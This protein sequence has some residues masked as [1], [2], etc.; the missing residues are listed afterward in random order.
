M[1]TRKDLLIAILYCICFYSAVL[2]ARELSDGDSAMMARSSIGPV[3]K[4]D[5]EKAHR[6]QVFKANVKFWLCVN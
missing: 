1:A 5:T 6:F 4:D 2:A 3:Y